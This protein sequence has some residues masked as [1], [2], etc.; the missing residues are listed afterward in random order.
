MER[1][2]APWRMAYV[3]QPGSAKEQMADGRCVFC[4]KAADDSDIENLLIHRGRHSFVL[5]NL[6]PYNNGH[7]MVAPYR[8][9]ASLDDLDPETLLEMMV[10]ARTAVR[11]LGFGIHP[12]AYNIGMNL[13]Q[14]AGAGIADHLHLHVVPRWNGDTNFMPVLSDT[15]VLPDSL[16]NSCRKLRDAWQALEQEQNGPH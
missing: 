6:F 16:E 12:D 5:M 10:L 1:L 7:V 13:G 14:V 15:K 9:T 4:K 8:H 3:D 11:V 2:Y